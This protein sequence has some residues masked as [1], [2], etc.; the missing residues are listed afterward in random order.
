MSLSVNGSGGSSSVTQAAINLAERS[1]SPFSSAN[2]KK[3]AEE[4]VAQINGNPMVKAGLS[5]IGQIFGPGASSAVA[6]AL[7]F[8]IGGGAFFGLF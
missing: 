1:G 4:E 2:G 7:N 5:L 6:S 3:H 8:I